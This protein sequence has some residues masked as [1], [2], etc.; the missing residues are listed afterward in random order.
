MHP[1]PINRDIELAADVADGP[2]SVVLEQV[3]NG[4]AVRMAI[5]HLLANSAPED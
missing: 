5:M 2:R 4:V 1:G 3:S